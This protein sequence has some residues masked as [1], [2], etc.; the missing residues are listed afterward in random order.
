MLAIIDDSK[1]D[2]SKL[3]TFSYYYNDDRYDEKKYVCDLMKQL[4]W[5]TNFTLLD[6]NEIPYLA[7]EAMYYQEQPYPG[8]ITI[9][10]H[11]M[12][13]KNANKATTVLLEGS[14]RYHL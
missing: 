1:V 11:N 9:A 4:K 6:P 7:E 10:K 14:S 13:K 12:I 2:K 8:I 3:S 5:D